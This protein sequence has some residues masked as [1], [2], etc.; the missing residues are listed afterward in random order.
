MRSKI[1][2]EG[3]IEKKKTSMRKETRNEARITE[4]F[5]KM[6]KLSHKKQTTKINKKWKRQRERERVRES[7]RERER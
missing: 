1:R 3:E 5:L 7:E 4:R 6:E 2:R